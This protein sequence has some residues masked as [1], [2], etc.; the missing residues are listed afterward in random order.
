MNTFL[1]YADFNQSAVC[2]DRQRLG[3]QRVECLQLLRGSW[4]NHPASKMWRGF[5]AALAAYAETIC[6]EWKKRG[7]KDTCHEKCLEIVTPSTKVLPPWL[8]REDFHAAM[9]SNL[10]RKN[11]DWY[12]QFGWREPDNLPYIWGNE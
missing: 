6:L 3:K 9:R 4:P 8:G 2:L 1:P 11:R 10:L 7:Y 12:G 5:E